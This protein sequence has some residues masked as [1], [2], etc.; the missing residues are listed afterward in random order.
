MSDRQ[1]WI[2]LD[3]EGESRERVKA[4]VE[5]KRWCGGNWGLAGATK[6]P[7]CIALRPLQAKNS[8]HRADRT[9]AGVLDTLFSLRSP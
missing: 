4:I 1:I 9:G 6:K 2:K 7:R 3:P 8:V 5:R